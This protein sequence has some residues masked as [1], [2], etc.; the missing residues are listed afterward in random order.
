MKYGAEMMMARNNVMG[1]DDLVFLI[2]A[3][4]KSPAPDKESELDMAEVQAELI[5]FSRLKPA[6]NMLII[7][8]TIYICKPENLQ[9]T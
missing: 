1:Q 8:K 2:S 3:S 5:G 6:Q 4:V 9:R 7:S